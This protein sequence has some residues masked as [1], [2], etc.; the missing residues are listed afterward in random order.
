MIVPTTTVVATMPLAA[1]LEQHLDRSHSLFGLGWVEIYEEP[2]GKRRAV[3]LDFR[4]VGLELIEPVGADQTPARPGRSRPRWKPHRAHRL[5]PRDHST[6]RATEFERSTTTHRQA[7][8][9]TTPVLLLWRG[10]AGADGAPIV[11]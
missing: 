11:D 5:T 10:S 8:A 7:A 4:G 9:V 1:T 3:F 2:A 6:E